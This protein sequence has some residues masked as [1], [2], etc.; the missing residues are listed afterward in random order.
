[1]AFPRRGKTRLRIT[2]QFPVAFATRWNR[3]VAAPALVIG[4]VDATDAMGDRA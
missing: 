3:P 4:A 2:G 1:M